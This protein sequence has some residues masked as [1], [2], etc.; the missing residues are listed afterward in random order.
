Q[1]SAKDRCLR[2]RMQIIVYPF[3]PF[4]L[5][6]NFFT[7]SKKLSAHPDGAIDAGDVPKFVELRR[8][9]MPG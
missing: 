2:R 1:R 7:A 9:A 4:M 8:A 6:F 5:I 3:Q